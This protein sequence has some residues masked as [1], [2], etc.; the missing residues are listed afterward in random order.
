M[1]RWLKKL[2]YL[3]KENHIEE[4]KNEGKYQRERIEGKKARGTK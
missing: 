1:K 3:K 2:K 4:E